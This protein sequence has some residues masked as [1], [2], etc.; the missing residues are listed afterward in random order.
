MSPEKGLFIVPEAVHHAGCAPIVKIPSQTEDGK[1]RLNKIGVTA[2]ELDRYF[3]A[4]L[5]MDA[6]PPLT[7]EP[8]KLIQF[9]GSG[10]IYPRSR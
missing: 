4:Q 10:E 3:W 6:L 2:L 1:K 9:H 8:A 5:S 7:A